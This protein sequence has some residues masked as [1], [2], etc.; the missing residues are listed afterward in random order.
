MSTQTDPARAPAKL[1]KV[2]KISAILWPSF[3]FAGAANSVF[4]AFL[5]PVKLFECTGVAPLSRIGAYSVGFLLFWLLCTGSSL[6]TA[7][8]LK[9]VP[10]AARRLPSAGPDQG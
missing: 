8:F 7:Y 5:D 1:S 9:R 3:L 6:A 2:Q 4:F 10:R